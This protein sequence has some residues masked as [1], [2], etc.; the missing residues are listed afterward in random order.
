MNKRR[1]LINEIANRIVGRMLTENI[2]AEDIAT[3]LE[4]AHSMRKGNPTDVVAYTN[5][6]LD[7]YSVR[8]DS[9]IQAALLM[10]SSISYAILNIVPTPSTVVDDADYVHHPGRDSKSGLYAIP[11]SD[12]VRLANSLHRDVLE[13]YMESLYNNLSK[14]SPDEDTGKK[15]EIIKR[16][17]EVQNHIVDRLEKFFQQH[18][19]AS[20]IDFN[21]FY[22]M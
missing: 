18:P 16:A 11:S 5:T 15:L 9:P 19:Q 22:K 3:F 4:R 13:P 1:K 6:A 8:G 12:R 2:S 21:A 20:K 10:A 17:I 7:D 14:L